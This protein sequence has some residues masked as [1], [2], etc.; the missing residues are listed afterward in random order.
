[1]FQWARHADASAEMNSVHLSRH[2]RTFI[3]L[4]RFNPNLITCLIAEM[5]RGGVTMLL[6]CLIRLTLV[7]KAKTRIIS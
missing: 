1:M 5:C 7:S 4:H 3:H 6:V 2:P